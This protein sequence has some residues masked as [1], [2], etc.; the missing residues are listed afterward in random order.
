MNF[1]NLITTINKGCWHDRASGNQCSDPGYN[2]GYKNPKQGFRDIMSYDCPDCAC[3]YNCGATTCP[4]AARISNTKLKYNNFP[5]GNAQNNCAQTINDNSVTI[6][7]FFVSSTIAQPSR[8]PS[9]KPSTNR[10]KQC[11]ANCGNPSTSPAP[12][13]FA[14]LS[15]AVCS[16]KKCCQYPSTGSSCYSACNA[17]TGNCPS[18]SKELNIASCASVTAP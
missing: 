14:C 1:V 3:N 5:I 12:T 18:A 11:I 15:P 16:M 13:K 9:K 6:A 17:K 7:S 8:R 10:Q 4:T 2:F